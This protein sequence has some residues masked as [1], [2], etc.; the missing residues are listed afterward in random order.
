MLKVTVVFGLLIV[1]RHC[2]WVLGD[3]KTLIKSE[4]IW[5]VLVHEAKDRQCFFNA[6]EDD[7][8]AKT[9]L[10]VKKELD[11]LDDL[12]NGDS[13]LFTSARWKVHSF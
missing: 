13:M 3:E 12:L 1:S 4:S 2:L 8:I 9:I 6:N 10:D 7:N 11:Q 5:E